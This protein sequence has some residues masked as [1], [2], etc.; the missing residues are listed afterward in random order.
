LAFS[1]AFSTNCAA[2]SSASLIIRAVCF[3]AES[4]A[5]LDDQ[6]YLKAPAE[7]FFQFFCTP[8]VVLR[9]VR[10]RFYICH[11]QSE[12]FRIHPKAVQEKHGLHL[13]QTSDGFVNS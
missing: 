4:T 12:V 1:L 5:L 6:L 7:D 2:F 9:N 8:S 3:F 10:C 13:D 11:F